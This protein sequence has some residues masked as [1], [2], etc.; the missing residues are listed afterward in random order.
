MKN[1]IATKGLYLSATSL[2]LLAI[3]IAVRPDNPKSQL[4]TTSQSEFSTRASSSDSVLTS[5]KRAPDASKHEVSYNLD[6]AITAFESQAH[7]QTNQL[8]SRDL[9]LLNELISNLNEFQNNEISR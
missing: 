9:E 3:F 1:L 4:S 7:Q 8:D 6:E 5:V 2:L